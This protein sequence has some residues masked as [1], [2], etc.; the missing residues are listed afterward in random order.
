MKKR[1]PDQLAE[2]NRHDTERLETLVRSLSMFGLRV[3]PLL[4]HEI[5]FK[6]ALSI[7]DEMD[8]SLIM[9]GSRGLSAVREMLAGRTFEN[10]ARLSRQAVL[11]VRH[12]RS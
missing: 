1:S 11:V 4:K 10:V 5:P 7:A 8:V 3:H 12:T 9:L 2:F 6:E